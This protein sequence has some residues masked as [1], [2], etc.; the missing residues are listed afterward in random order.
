MVNNFI[1]TVFY[2][3]RNSE[4]E[5]ADT[6]FAW[7]QNIQKTPE[8]NQRN[9]ECHSSAHSWSPVGEIGAGVPLSLLD[10]KAWSELP[11]LNI[12]HHF[13]TEIIVLHLKSEAVA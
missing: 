3:H 9:L 12:T 8:S 1:I 13:K 11:F 2:Y 4:F 5:V 7:D 10:T 6:E